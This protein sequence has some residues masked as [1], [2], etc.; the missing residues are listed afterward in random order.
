MQKCNCHEHSISTS[1]H[2]KCP[3]TSSDGEIHGQSDSIWSA[4]DGIQVCMMFI[5]SEEVTVILIT[6]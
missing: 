4:G 2:P 3:W 5:L 6:V 1:K